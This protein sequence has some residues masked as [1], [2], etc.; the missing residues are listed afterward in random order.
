LLLREAR[1]SSLGLH[2]SIL[3]ILSFVSCFFSFFFSLSLNARVLLLSL[4][5]PTSIVRPGACPAV[6]IFAQIK[7]DGDDHRKYSRFFRRPS[8]HSSILATVHMSVRRKKRSPLCIRCNPVTLDSSASE[9][10][11]AFCFSFFILYRTR[12]FSVGNEDT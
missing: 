4:D 3:R 7:Q 10:S 5:F 2:I 9:L 11:L 1:G 6:F 8:I 12:T